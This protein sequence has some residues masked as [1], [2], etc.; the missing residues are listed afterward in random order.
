V[1]PGSNAL[2]VY[3]KEDRCRARA[4]SKVYRRS[5]VEIAVGVGERVAADVG[6]IVGFK[7][8][9]LDGV[10]TTSV[11]VTLKFYQGRGLERRNRDYRVPQHDELGTDLKLLHGRLKA[12][13]L[14]QWSDVD[15]AD[16]TG[17][18]RLQHQWRR[19]GWR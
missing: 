2:T 11:P 8:V 18:G 13:C 9:A 19:S 5:H 7:S 3:C 10:V 12:S 14:I 17:L 16:H 6:D 4:G 15:H 1:M